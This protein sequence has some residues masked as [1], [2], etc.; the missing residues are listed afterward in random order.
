MALDL[1]LIWGF[2]LAIGVMMYVL[3]DGFDLG[4]GMLT[5]LARSDEER[6]MMTATRHGSSLA[7]AACSLPFR[8]PTAS[9][10]RL[11]IFRS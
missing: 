5:F 4:V 2:I 1:P 8:L 7:A 3:L 9:S 10:C 11:S 6:N